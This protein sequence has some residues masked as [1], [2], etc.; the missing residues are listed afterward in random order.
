[1]SGAA[2]AGAPLDWTSAFAAEGLAVRAASAA[3]TTWLPAPTLYRGGSATSAGASPGG[4]GGAAGALLILLILAAV[5]A[6]RR[7]VVTADR[8]PRCQFVLLPERPG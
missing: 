4:G 3:G 5:F 7:L 1:M 2:S 8:P 6:G